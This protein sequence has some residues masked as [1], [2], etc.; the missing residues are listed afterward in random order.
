VQTFASVRVE[1]VEFLRTGNMGIDTGYGPLVVK[2]STF[3]GR[4]GI[5][6]RGADLTVIGSAF[7][8]TGTGVVAL[9]TNQNPG[10][11]L[12]FHANRFA[13]IGDAIEL[14][15]P[16]GSDGDFGS[17]DLADN[18]WGC[19]EGPAAASC[20]PIVGGTG[21]AGA[22]PVASWLELRAIDAPTVLAPG[23][24]ATLTFGLVGSGTGAVATDFPPTPLT[25][26]ATTGSVMPAAATLVN[27]RATVTYTAPDAPG[28]YTVTAA[29]DNGTASVVLNAP[30]PPSSHETPSVTRTL[31]PTD[32]TPGE[33]TSSGTG[34]LLAP[35]LMLGAITSLSLLVL[36]Q[37]R[38]R[39]R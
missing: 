4:Y 24:S 22:D 10:P 29:L 39:R 6:N 33:P 36:S 8:T 9:A 25:V 19:N 30:V 12:T 32:E 21:I 27:G 5:G 34:G 14:V 20:R 28:M 17:I 26:S 11:A 38:R 13:G 16:D 1:D 7:E 37:G 35:V 31:P 23:A 18:W 2:S 15:V 3:R